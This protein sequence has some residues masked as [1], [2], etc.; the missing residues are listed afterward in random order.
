M[1]KD[2]LNLASEAKFTILGGKLFQTV[3]L[4]T[5]TLVLNTFNVIKHH[6]KFYFLFIIFIYRPRLWFYVVYLMFYVKSVIRYWTVNIV[7]GV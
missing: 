4:E 2:F 3:T 7:I 5:I 6:L 1:F